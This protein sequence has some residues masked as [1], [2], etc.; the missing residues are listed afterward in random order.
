MTAQPPPGSREA[1]DQGCT[2]PVLDNGYGRGSGRVDEA[3]QPLYWKSEGCP[4]HTPPGPEE[5]TE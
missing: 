2:C 1:V 5:D 3:G 4:L